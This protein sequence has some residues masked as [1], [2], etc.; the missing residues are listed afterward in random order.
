[1]MCFYLKSDAHAFLCRKSWMK[2]Y[3]NCIRLKMRSSMVRN[4]AEH[5]IALLF[6][7]LLLATH[8]NTQL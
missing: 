5:C 3:V 2:S 6:I 4:T 7:T 8:S 1:M